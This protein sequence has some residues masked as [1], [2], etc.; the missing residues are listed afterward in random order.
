MSMCIH[1]PVD[2]YCAFKEKE[3]HHFSFSSDCACCRFFGFRHCL[4]PN[5]SWSVTCKVTLSVVAGDLNWVFLGVLPL[6]LLWQEQEACA[7]PEWDKGQGDIKISRK[8]YSKQSYSKGSEHTTRELQATRVTE[9]LRE[10]TTMPGS[11]VS[12]GVKGLQ[13]SA[14]GASCLDVLV[15]WMLQNGITLSLAP[16]FSCWLKLPANYEFSLG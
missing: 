15:H 1:V 8:L 13:T 10:Y 2:T 7:N 6:I 11:D 3:A 16:V 12:Y 4:I 14:A 5:P 9:H